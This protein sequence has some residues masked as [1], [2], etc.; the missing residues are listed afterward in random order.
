MLEGLLEVRSRR[1][2][3]IRLDRM[4]DYLGA[5]FGIFHRG[6]EELFSGA[7]IEGYGVE[8]GGTEGPPALKSGPDDELGHE[9][10]SR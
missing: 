4:L 1:W 9:L 7:L 2:G 5:E 10:S 3:V 8:L 6:G